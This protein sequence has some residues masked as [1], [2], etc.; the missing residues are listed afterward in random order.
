M[1][2]TFGRFITLAPKHAVPGRGGCSLQDERERKCVDD[3]K[4][5]KKECVDPVGGYEVFNGPGC[6]GMN[7][8]GKRLPVS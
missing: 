2:T 5:A 3:R 4:G 8:R 1:L 6:N 7:D